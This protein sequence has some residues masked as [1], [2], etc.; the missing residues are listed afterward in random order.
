MTVFLSGILGM[1]Y[2]CDY[3][4]HEALAPLGPSV[5]PEGWEPTRDGGRDRCPSCTKAA[6]GDASRAAARRARRDGP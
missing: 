6:R 1:K 5:P 4:G 2:V 3:C